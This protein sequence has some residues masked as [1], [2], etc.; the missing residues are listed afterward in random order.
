MEDEQVRRALDRGCDREGVMDVLD[1]SERT[2]FYKVKRACAY[3]FPLD[4]FSRGGRPPEKAGDQEVER[5]SGGDH[6][7][8]QQRLD[9]ADLGRTETWGVTT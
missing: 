2:P 1:G 3:E 7:D 4:A 8:A 6:S 5:K 9:D